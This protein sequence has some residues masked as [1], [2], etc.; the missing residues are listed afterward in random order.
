[1]YEI[2]VN[3]RITEGMNMDVSR[4]PVRCPQHV[5]I[6][7]GDIS[8]RYRKWL[9][10]QF[11]NSAD[12]IGFLSQVNKLAKDQAVLNLVCGGVYGNKIGQALK[13]FIE[14]HKTALDALES[15][16]E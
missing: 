9:D 12:L 6:G 10:D 2:T 11:T 5:L 8:K 16:T 15:L 7:V 4:T 13:D 3:K 1:M 14:E